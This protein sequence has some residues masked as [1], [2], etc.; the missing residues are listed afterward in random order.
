M[1]RRRLWESERTELLKNKRKEIESALE[2]R[3]ER[4]SE[5]LKN[6]LK[7]LSEED[8]RK[9][10]FAMRKITSLA[11]TLNSLVVEASDIFGNMD[12]EITDDGNHRYRLYNSEDRYI[13][14]VDVVHSTGDKLS[15]E[16]IL[17]DGKADAYFRNWDGRFSEDKYTDIMTVLDDFSEYLNTDNNTPLVRN[18][19]DTYSYSFGKALGFSIM[20]DRLLD[21]LSVLQENAKELND[22]FEDEAEKILDDIERKKVR[23]LKESH[24]R[25]FRR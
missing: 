6:T 19:L 9:A 17:E 24:L 22:K 2:R 18:F 5:Q 11:D 4:S 8:K 20:L 16:Y 12:F 3:Y 10:K 23:G 1:I 25:R 21:D 14:A 7:K 13:V 15:L